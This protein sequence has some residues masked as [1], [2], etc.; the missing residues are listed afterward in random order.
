MSV[1]TL[2]DTLYA[3]TSCCF[4]NPTIQINKRTFK[5]IRLLGEGGYSFVYL[6]QDV[7]TGRLYALKKI[8]CPPGD[9]Q[10]V[11]DAMRE[12][13]MYRMFQHDNIIKLLNTSITTERDGTKIVY[14]FLP[15]YKRGNLQDSI[16][17][18]NLTKTHFPEQDLLR[19]FRKICYAVRVLHSYRLP[20]VA[21]RNLEEEANPDSGFAQNT[22]P[23]A[24]YYYTQQ[25]S[26]EDD[27][28]SQQEEGA[29]VPFAH[30][31]LKPG[32]ILIADDGLTPLLTDFGSIKR[33]RIPVKSRRD[34]MMQEELA[35]EYSTMPYR[36][37]ELYE[38]Q[39]GKELN[40]KV[41]IWSLGC[42]FFA[43]AYGQS[44]FEASSQE[45][46]GSMSLAILNGNYKFPPAE[47]DPYSESVRD[48][49]KFI[50]TIDPSERPDIHAVIQKLDGM[51][52]EQAAA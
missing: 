30:R 25:P 27:E 15:Y 45:M 17:A 8:R 21:M 3:I 42:L 1:S 4:P 7:P 37:P 28:S 35:A 2:R 22:M 41:D 12:V 9:Q 49:I 10:A 19:F 26:E 24:P 39:P 47:Q 16:N 50:L 43:T 33:A 20:K 18:N 40:E 34:A 31:D 5:V 48:L 13:D 46:G 32:N 44:P 51:L 6:V 14:M 38:V 36:A 11:S 23:N 29:P 52:E